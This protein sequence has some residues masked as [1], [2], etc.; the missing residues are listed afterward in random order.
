MSSQLTT[1]VPTFDGTNYLVW[2]CA[3]KAYL[4]LQGLFGYCDGSIAIPQSHPAVAAV[5]AVAATQSTLAVEAV[6]AQDTYTP[7][8]NDMLVWKKSD[9]MALGA[10][11][12][13]LSPSIQQLVTQTDTEDL[14]ERLHDTYTKDSL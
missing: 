5:A 2:S 1:L 10:I 8:V 4:Q 12:L 6:E 13:C 7:T 11:I 14:W 9:N 3:M